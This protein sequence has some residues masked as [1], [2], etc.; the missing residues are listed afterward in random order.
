MAP[1][2]VANSPVF[3]FGFEPSPSLGAKLQPLKPKQSPSLSSSPRFVA[4]NLA[5][6]LHQR[7]AKTEL[8]TRVAVIGCGFV[9]EHLVE[10][11]GEHYRVIGFD[12]SE[13][14]CALLRQS[15]ADKGMDK[16]TTT[17]DERMLAKADAYLIS[18][19]TLL[20]SDNTIDTSYIES[21][22]VTVSKYAKP[23]NVIIME[24]SVGVGMTRQLLA[25]LRA[26]GVFCGMSPERVDPGRT[27]PAVKDIPKVISG[28]DVESLEKIKTLYGAAFKQLVPVSC[29]EAAEMTKLFEN[30]YR[31]INIAFVNEIADACVMKNIDPLEVVRAASSKPFG[32]Q[33]FMPGLGVG[34]HCIPINPYYLFASYNNDPSVLPLL[35]QASSTMWARPATLA[36]EL[37]SE[38]A[39]QMSPAKLRVLVVGAAFKPGE[40]VI[41]CSPTVLFTKALQELGVAKVEWIDPFVSQKQVPE[42]MKFAD[43]NWDARMIDEEFDV[44]CVGMRQKGLDFGVLDQCVQSRVAYYCA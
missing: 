35:R 42:V 43:E 23:G 41:S 15:F 10:T 27:F 16:I 8:H 11:F 9:G 36:K 12:I 37:V 13:S 32:F 20:K 33:P 19:P 40:S 6:L 1:A 30:C 39:E 38:M 4:D 22:L 18:V 26:Q 21:A 3:S 31:M 24:S 5:E 14:R 25:P 2:A 7:Q 44:V 29:P 34:G 17:S 28:L